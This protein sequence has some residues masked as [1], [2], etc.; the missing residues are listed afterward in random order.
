MADENTVQLA[1]GSDFN[2]IRIH[3]IVFNINEIQKRYTVQHNTL[4]LK[5]NVL[6]V[7]VHKNHHQATLV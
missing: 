6:Y 7:S 3:P 1:K 2:F 4:M 5:N